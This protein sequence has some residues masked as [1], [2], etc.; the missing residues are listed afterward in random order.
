MGGFCVFFMRFQQLTPQYQ[1]KLMSLLE[2]YY[3]LKGVNP[4][5]RKEMMLLKDKKPKYWRNQRWW[6][7][8]GIDSHRER[9]GLSKIYS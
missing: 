7:M 3:F 8:K 4:S 2:A 6:F 5:K 1:E 9:M